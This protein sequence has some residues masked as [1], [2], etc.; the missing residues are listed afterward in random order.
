MKERKLTCIVC[1]MGCPLTVTM[2]DN[3]AV[4]KVEGNTCPRGDVYAKQECTDPRRTVTSTVRCADGRPLAVKTDRPIPK[5]KVMACMA[6]I[7]RTVAT[8]PIAVGDV[9]VEDVFGSRLVATENR[10]R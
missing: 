7:N 5:D 2:D 1:P 9:L 6:I 4:A 8:P 10:D 3:G